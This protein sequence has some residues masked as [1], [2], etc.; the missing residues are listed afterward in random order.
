MTTARSLQSIVAVT[1]VLLPLRA[2][3]QQIPPTPQ[4][5]PDAPKPALAPAS[6]PNPQAPLSPNPRPTL[7]FEVPHSW[8]PTKA[9]RASHVPEP[10]LANSA[11]LDDLIHN[12]VLE[13]SLED[14]ITLAL[15]N[16]LDLSIARYNLAIAAADVL[17]TRAGGIFRGVNTGVV[18]NTPGGGIGG[19]GSSSSGAGA[20]GTNGGA[21]GAGSGASGL[22]SSTLG[23]GTAVNT[24]DPLITANT[25]LRHYTQP[26]SNISIYGVKVLHDNT[27]VGN[28]G[29][30]ESFPTGTTVSF[31]LNNDRV[32]TNSPSTFLNPELDTYYQVL[33]QQ[34]LLAGFGFGPNLRYLRIAQ[35]DQRISDQAFE[36]QVTT[37]V[38]QI[39][40]M[41]WDPRQRLRGRAG[42]IPLRRLR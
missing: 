2:P 30:T 19:F 35:N 41:Y 31:S 8:N 39:A 29:F 38:T 3:A 25:S 33:L 17:R 20:G 16:N 12:G 4:P 42:Q 36:L 37:T 1:L 22:V 18:Q 7:N 23:T 14:A 28:V 32:T 15:Q 6:Q 5:Q 40:N 21:G 24:Y 34:Q 9:Y 27:I 13:L 26:L 11:H 10:D